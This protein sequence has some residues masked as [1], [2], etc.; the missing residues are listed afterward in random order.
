[1]RGMIPQLAADTDPAVKNGAELL[2]RMIKDIVT[3]QAST[4]VLATSLSSRP[5][6]PRASSPPSISSGADQSDKLSHYPERAFSLPRFI[7]LLRERIYVINPF[8]RTYLVSWLTVLDSVPELELVSF[9]PEFLDG[10]L[11]FLEDPTV[12]VR[13][14]TQN[15]LADFLKEIR[16]VAEVKK[17]REEEW[18]RRDEEGSHR[19]HNRTPSQ[20]SEGVDQNQEEPLPEREGDRNDRALDMSDEEGSYT[21]DG[22]E[23]E[24]SGAWVPGQGVDVDHAGIIEILLAHLP[25]PGK[26]SLIL[27]LSGN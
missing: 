1:M 6:S 8:T 4:Y 10:L 26:Y 16:E 14:A 18:K 7:P 11:R 25:F 20:V 5:P 27:R 3:E 12:D 19:H 22:D 2:D 24:G 23:G 21:D 15:I 17:S 9:L 13:T